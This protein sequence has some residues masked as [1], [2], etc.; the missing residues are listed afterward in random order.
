MVMPRE[1]RA[2]AANALAA[3]ASGQS[4]PAAPAVAAAKDYSASALVQ[5]WSSGMDVY[6]L[7][8]EAHAPDP[9][10]RVA[11]VYACMTAIA[12]N[13]ARVTMRLSAGQPAG[14]AGA[15]GARRVRAGRPGGR[16]VYAGQAIH[17]AAPGEI[18]ATGPAAALLERPNDEQTWPAFVEALLGAMYTGGRAHIWLDSPGVEPTA[19]H[20]IPGARSKPR[21]VRDRLRTR[22]VGWTVYTPDGTPV[23]VPAADLVTLTLW[24]PQDPRAGLSPIAPGRMAIDSY[25]QAWRY[26]AT[27]WA[28]DCEPGGVLEMDAPLDLERDRQAKL[29]WEQRHGGPLNARR[30]AIVWQGKYHAITPSMADMVFAEGSRMS[31]EDI[32]AVLRTD[33]AVA[34]FIGATGDSSAYVEAALERWW[35][36]TIAPLLDKIAEALTV[37]VMGRFA[38]G[39]EVWADVED[40]PIYQ[41][42]RRA[43]IDAAGKLFALGRPWRDIDEWLN[44]GLPPRA[45]DEQAFLPGNLL[46][47]DAVLEGTLPP[48]DEGGPLPGEPLAPSDPPD[49]DPDDDS[50]DEPNERT[51]A[52]IEKAAADRV[53]RLWE[54]SWT[55]LA[56][57][58]GGRLRAYWLGQE[59]RLLRRLRELQQAEGRSAGATQTRSEGRVIRLLVDVFEDGDQRRRLRATVRG[60]LADTAELGARQIADEAG[61]DADAAGRLLNDAR[62]SPALAGAMDSAAMRWGSTI[63]GRTRQVLRRELLDGVAAGEDV[64]RLADRVQGV[65]QNRRKGAIAYARN[66]MAQGLSES[67]G[68]SAPAAGRDRKRWMH[69]RGPGERRPAHIAAEAAHRAGIPI[70]E[71][72]LVNGVAMDRPRDPT[73]PPGE[74]INCQCVAL[75]GRGGTRRAVERVLAAGFVGAERIKER[76]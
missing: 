73:A 23:N 1:T 68:H 37:G 56:K 44:L 38:R 54:R 42:M 9:A 59:R 17:R 26:N 39:L 70:D 41:R 55:P 62:T 24:D 13:A 32:C 43:Q 76:K 61:L 72:F 64:R 69:S 74:T 4:A 16:R 47:V 5:Q 15:F 71:P 52:R 51:A 30:L 58:L 65:M 35:Q 8:R 22:L 66:I 19:M 31:R 20:V 57:R 7:T 34:G 33:P 6:G 40:V 45:H 14:T 28:N 21:T 53:W 3:M 12:T 67:R 63:D 10:R 60:S 27:A 50:D 11:W 2:A 75:Y 25:Y 36:D 29:A 46:P 48:A 49:E 18:I